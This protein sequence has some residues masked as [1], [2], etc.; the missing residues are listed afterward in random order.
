MFS[1]LAPRNNTGNS[2]I[3]FKLLFLNNFE[4]SDLIVVIK[5]LTLL[6]VCN[7][8]SSNIENPGLYT[9]PPIAIE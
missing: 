5:Y 1:G 2:S 7:D 4:T 8:I 6:T 9:I 3:F